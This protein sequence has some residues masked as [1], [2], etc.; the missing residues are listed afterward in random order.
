MKPKSLRHRYDLVEHLA[1]VGLHMTEISARVGLAVTTIRK[2]LKTPESIAR[3]EEINKRIREQ[4]ISEAAGIS[5]KFDQEAPQAFETLKRLNR[6]KTDDIENP[7][8]HAVSLQAATQILDRAPS[9]PSRKGD[10]GGKH[11]HIH[12]PQKQF[13]NAQEALRDI[14]IVPIEPEPVG[15][16][17]AGERPEP[18]VCDLGSPPRREG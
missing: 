14:G 2:H 6:G 1:A 11:L 17:E 8:P 16:L 12:L 13:D 5:E 9:V 4:I 18:P 15:R 3:V 10:E 7:V